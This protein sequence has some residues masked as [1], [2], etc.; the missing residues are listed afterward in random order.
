MWV[1]LNKHLPSSYGKW[2][3]IWWEWRRLYITE[4]QVPDVKMQCGPIFYWQQL[5]QERNPAHWTREAISGLIIVV[6]FPALRNA[7]IE[8]TV[9]AIK[10]NLQDRCSFVSNHFLWDLHSIQPTHKQNVSHQPQSPRL[11]HCETSLAQKDGTQSN[12]TTHFSALENLF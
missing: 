10:D 5:G 3:R 6:P 8:F 4:M 9:I 2:R 11:D 1:M 12:R 7:M